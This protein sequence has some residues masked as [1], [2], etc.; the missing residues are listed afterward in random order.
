MSAPNAVSYKTLQEH[1]TGMPP[2]TYWFFHPDLSR[3]PRHVFKYTPFVLKVLVQASGLQ[4]SA[5]R[6]ICAYSDRNAVDDI[7]EIGEELSIDP[8]LFGETMIVQAR[9]NF[10]SGNCSLS[11]LHL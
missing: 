8:R 7:F 5:F 2:W 3:E 1:L 6:T 10:G 4:E 9:K 11:R